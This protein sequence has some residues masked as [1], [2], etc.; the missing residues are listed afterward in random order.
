MN[1]LTSSGVTLELPA[2]LDWP[3][4]YSWQPVE[5]SAD[6]SLTGAL[7]VESASRQAG[8]P[9]TLQGGDDR[10]WIGRA[11]LDQLRAWAVI[12]GQPMTLALRGASYNV[13]FRHQDQGLEA[14]MIVSF[15]DPDAATWYR[16]TLRLMEI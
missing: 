11:L 1:T 16:V 8:R 9:I 15:S 12:P 13:I 3:D 6:Y 4:E 7:V 14:E 2:D 5:Q 10:A